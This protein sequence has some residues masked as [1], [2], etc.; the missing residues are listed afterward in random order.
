MV[1]EPSSTLLQLR[2]EYVAACQ[3]HNQAV[4][5]W[6]QRITLMQC[7]VAGALFFKWSWSHSLLGAAFMAVLVLLALTVL[8][9]FAGLLTHGTK[10]RQAETKKTFESTRKNEVEKYLSSLKKG[11][12]QWI[13]R[14]GNYLA[15]LPDAGLLYYFGSVS[16][17]QHVLLDAHRTVLDVQVA[18]KQQ[19]SQS[20]SSTTTHGRR[21]VLMPS[22][23][24]G[25]L[26]KGKSTTETTTHTSVTAAYALE[27]QIQ[28]TSA[29]QPFWITFPFGPDGK[30]AGNWKELV[31][32]LR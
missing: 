29:Q 25:M 20:T 14:D 8:H 32:Q 13:Q 15:I 28:L 19:V 18:S 4:G 21:L 11:R 22:R 6:H 30:A 12:Y 9:L 27:I 10:K 31:S 1:V 23:H 7:I 17:D 2:N 3:A 5:L 16:K 26:G 24:I